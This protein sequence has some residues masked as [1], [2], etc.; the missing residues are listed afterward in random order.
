MSQIE[1]YQ[2]KQTKKQDDDSSGY[3]NWQS[4]HFIETNL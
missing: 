2:T 4:I 3:V 1:L